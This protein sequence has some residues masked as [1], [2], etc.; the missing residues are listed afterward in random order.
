MAKNG[1]LAARTG[2]DRDKGVDGDN[3]EQTG[4]PVLRPKISKIFERSSKECEKERNGG[5]KDGRKERKRRTF[6]D[7]V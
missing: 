3:T 5:G 6:G 1:E 7:V 4:L 2:H